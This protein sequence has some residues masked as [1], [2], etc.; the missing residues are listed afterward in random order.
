MGISPFVPFY[1]LSTARQVSTLKPT[2]IEASSTVDSG[3]EGH[4]YWG[5]KRRADNIY[6][7]IGIEEILHTST[8]IN[9]HTHA[10][11]LMDRAADDAQYEYKM[12]SSRLA[13]IVVGA[14]F[15]LIG[16][17]SVV[18]RFVTAAVVLCERRATRA[19]G[20]QRG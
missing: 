11:I 9:P 4:I 15:T 18:L 13:L 14:I 12:T 10:S 5:P 16:T 6:Q 20:R 8:M 7:Q 3:P 17:I 2:G 19:A 1:I